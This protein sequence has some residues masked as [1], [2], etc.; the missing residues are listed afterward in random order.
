[1][2]DFEG[3]FES[4]KEQLTNDPLIMMHISLSTI[5]S[6]SDSDSSDYDDAKSDIQQH[7]QSRDWTF[8]SAGTF[9]PTQTNSSAPQPAAVYQYGRD[10]GNTAGLFGRAGTTVVTQRRPARGQFAVTP[11]QMNH[12]VSSDDDSRD[13]DR[14]ATR[15]V[16]G[17]RALALTLTTQTFLMTRIRTHKMTILVTLTVLVTRIPTPRA[18]MMTTS[19]WRMRATR[20]A[21]TR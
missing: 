16:L 15:G 6:M 7:V 11:Y 20:P 17:A 2:A 18:R 8:T 10:T 21:T 14:S 19:R 13:G 5:L 12:D 3:D 9:V 1:M 4:F